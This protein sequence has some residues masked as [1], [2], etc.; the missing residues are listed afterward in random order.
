MSHLPHKNIQNVD[1]EPGNRLYLQHKLIF[2]FVVE[3]GQITSHQA[4]ILLG[5][6]QRRARKILGEMVGQGLLEQ[7]GSYKNTVY[8]RREKAKRKMMLVSWV[9]LRGRSIHSI[10]GMLNQSKYIAKGR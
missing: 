1:I 6:K 7:Q 9:L 5:V 3:N 4:E 10:S 2:E 8:V